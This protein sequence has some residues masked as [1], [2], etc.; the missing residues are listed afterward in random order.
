MKIMEKWSRDH[1]CFFL[2]V[3][4]P[5]SISVENNEKRINKWINGNT[6]NKIE[7][8]VPRHVFIFSF[9]FFFFA[10]FSFSGVVGSPYSTNRSY[11]KKTKN[12]KK[13][14]KR[15][16]MKKKKNCLNTMFLI[17]LFRHF[18]ISVEKMKNEKNGCSRRPQGLLAPGGKKRK[19][20][21]M[22]KWNNGPRTI[23]LFFLFFVF[24]L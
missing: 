8:M 2:L 16:H 11:K 18:S 5:F 23:F 13:H 10:I 21:K 12:L 14:E 3:F 7:K 19:R 20:K 4:L 17:Y 9:F 22:K 1:F 15:K 6:I 24:F